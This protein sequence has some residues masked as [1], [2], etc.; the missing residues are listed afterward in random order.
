MRIHN[1]YADADGQSRFRDIDVE[2][3]RELPSGKTSAQHPATGLIFRETPGDYDLDWHPAP[4]RQYVINLD[5]PVEIT[6]SDGERRIIGA[7]EVLL[8]EDTTGAG[9][10]SKAVGGQVRRSIFIPIE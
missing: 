10:L 6:A 4:R 5:A 2:W 7:G 8:V 9:H 3:A 1:L